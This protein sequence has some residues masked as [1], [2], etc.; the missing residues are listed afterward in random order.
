ML[1][2]L[3]CKKGDAGFKE[4][5]NVEGEDYTTEFSIQSTPA[6]QNGPEV[7]VLPLTDVS[8]PMSKQPGRSAQLLQSSELGRQSL[9]YLKEIGQGWFG[10]VLIGQVNSGHAHSQVLVKELKVSASVQEQMLFLEETQPYRILQHPNL[11]QCLTQCTEIS[12]HLLVMEF[13]PLGD[14]KG[15]LRS[16]AC[17]ESAAPDPPTLQ[18]MG[19]ELCCGLL[20]LHSNNYTHS[21]LALRNC[22]LAADLTV[23]IGDYGLAHSRYRDDYLVTSDQLWVPLRWIA[24]ELI[25]EVHGNLLVVEQTKASNIWSLGV[26]LWELF[27]LGRQ[28]YD[29]YSDRQVLSYVIKEQ[30]LKLPKPQIKHLQGDRWYEVMQ[31]CWL[32]PEQRPSVEEVHLLLTYLSVK[33]SGELEEEFDKR[34]NSMKPNCVTD[35]GSHHEAELSSYPLLERFTSDGFQPDGDDVLTV[36]QTSQGLNFEYKW[37]RGR[38]EPYSPI[39]GCQPYPDVYYG[40]GDMLSLGVSPSG[41]GDKDCSSNARPLE[42]VPVLSARSPSV[43]GDY[44]IRIEEPLGSNLEQDYSPQDDDVVAED[45]PCGDSPSISLSM[46]SL[47]EKIVRPIDDTTKCSTTCGDEAGE[48][49]SDGS[50]SFHDPLAASSSQEVEERASSGDRNEALKDQTDFTVV[51]CEDE[52]SEFEPEPSAQTS[53]S[54]SSST[55]WTSNVSSNNN[56]SSE[57]REQVG[58]WCNRRLKD[59]QDEDSEPYGPESWQIT[60][61]ES[62][63][64]DNGA[65][66]TGAEDQYYD[67]QEFVAQEC[68]VLVETGPDES[69][70]ENLNDAEWPV[71]CSVMTHHPLALQSTKEAELPALC[72][73]TSPQQQNSNDAELSALRSVTSPQQQS[74]NSGELSTLRSV[75]SPQ[76]QTSNNG[77]LS[78][79]CSVTSTQEQSSNDGELSALCSVMSTQEQ[80]LNDGELS[81][82]RS[83]TAHHPLALQSSK[84][85]ELSALRSVMGPQDENSKEAELSTLCSVTTHHPLASPDAGDVTSAREMDPLGVAF[86]GHSEPPTHPEPTRDLDFPEEETSVDGSQGASLR[87]CGDLSSAKAPESPER[88]IS[89]DFNQIPSD[90]EDEDTMELTSGVFTDLSSERSDAAASFR[91]LQKQVGTPDSLDSLDMLSTA[92]S[93]D[94][95]SLR[96]Y[97]PCAQPKALDSGYDTENYESPEF[98]FK[99]SKEAEAVYYQEQSLKPGEMPISRY[100][101]QSLE[102]AETPISHYQEQSIEPGEMPIS[103][104]Q[105]QSLEPADTP[106][107]HYQEQSTE[108]GEMPISRYQEQSLEPAETPISHYQEQ[109]LEPAETPISHYQEQSTEPGEMPI[110]HYQEQSLEPAETPISHYQEQSLEPMEMPISHYQEQSL[111]PMEMPISCYQEQSLEPVEMPISH[112]QDKS[113]EPMEMPISCY[114]EQSLEPAETPISHYQEQSLEPA[115]MLISRYHE[116]SLEPAEMPIPRYQEQSLEPG[117]MPISRY[118][119]QSLEPGEMPISRYQE[120]SLEPA[121]MPISHYQEQS[122]EAGEMPILHYQEQSLEPAEMPIPRYQE[123][124]LEPAE[125]PI[126]RYQEQSLEPG[127]MPISHYQEQSLEPAETLISHYQEQSLE[128]EEMQILHYQDQ[129]LEPAEMPISRYQEQSLEPEEMPI[130]RYQ[131]QSLEPGEM[132]ISRSVSGD[133]QGLDAKNPYRDSAYFS[134][135]DSF[136]REEEEE[137]ERKSEE[138]SQE[139]P[140]S[141]LRLDPAPGIAENLNEVQVRCAPEVEELIAKRSSPL[142]FAAKEASSLQPPLIIREESVDE[143]LGLECPKETSAEGEPCCVSVIKSASHRT[144][145]LSPPQLCLTKACAVK[146]G[147]PGSITLTTGLHAEEEPSSGRESP[148]TPH[149]PKCVSPPLVRKEN[150]AGDS[151]EDDEEDEENEDS[152][153]SDE[154]LRSYNIQE[155][156]EE[157]EEEHGAVPIIITDTSGA[158]HLRSLL[159]TPNPPPQ[160]VP[161]EPDRRKKAVSFYNDVTV[162]LFDQESPTLDE[163]DPDLPQ[164]PPALQEVQQTANKEPS[165]LHRGGGGSEWDGEMAAKPVKTSF[166]TALSPAPRGAEEEPAP[167][168]ALKP[169]LHVP[170]PALGIPKPALD[171]PKPALAV[172]LSRFSVSPTPL[173][174]FSIT[175]VADHVIGPLEEKLPSGEKM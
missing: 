125:M 13:C 140:K 108:P 35:S 158:G 77:E 82:L 102:P 93:C 132:P 84:E 29:S 43:A 139:P 24:P 101:E 119:E 103:H 120:Q 107:S 153:E 65:A 81:V 38:R 45:R 75:T 126:L 60:E 166:I 162:Y 96:M 146:Q 144:F 135:Y 113:L 62:V 21:D 117:E 42:L 97:T 159:K 7:Y 83:V 168:P 112:Y 80:S 172:Q 109:S 156:S 89:K 18:R 22:L 68:S 161:E 154:E 136:N 23:K 36:T 52:N 131:E 164:V 114:Q 149:V 152:D 87:S 20:H 118:Q 148:G 130:S 141:A 99:E 1:A 8:G 37:E 32:Q 91:S 123:Q 41:Y 71:L 56:V 160:N 16:C 34:W 4:L 40:A 169:A 137:G 31:F 163:A 58:V 33:G 175:Q 167:E 5:D 165:D 170:T 124:S 3:C 51:Q 157:S 6:A 61:P 174:R 110:S 88:L 25:D 15:Y 27:E 19:C 9:L 128:P 73:V 147:A 122:L 145:T 11:L 2:C 92:S 26:A 72:S 127:K 94:A 79:L 63:E 105:E 90:S 44:F 106:I 17:S 48:E 66:S 12:P 14:V 142:T 86:I 39:P 50:G 76:Q 95:F 10:K 85:A 30:Q 64:G 151:A 115:E 129:S 133:L 143:G 100:Q 98:V 171:A 138:Q 54:A 121:E 74:S 47:L 78:A 104:Y 55:N 28:P 46:E 67:A 155:H 111:E 49:D 134:D 173:S 70:E 116:Q 150:R 59:P 69:Q 53:R 57:P